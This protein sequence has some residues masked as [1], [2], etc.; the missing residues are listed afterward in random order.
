M[1]KTKNTR[2]GKKSVF[3]KIRKIF[4]WVLIVLIVIAG[5][6]AL[7]SYYYG[8]RIVRE[9]LI[10][11]VEKGSKGLY[12]VKMKNLYFNL[13][14]GRVYVSGFQLIPDTALYNRQQ[15]KDTL[16][17]MLIAINIAKFQVQ[18]I[19]FYKL[20]KDR[21]LVIRKIL[22]ENPE[23]TLTVRRP[24]EKKEKKESPQKQLSIP[25]P[26]ALNSLHILE[27]VLKDGKLLFDNRTVSPAEKFSIPSLN[28]SLKNIQVDSTHTGKK[29]I[30]NTDDIRV[31]LKGMKM[32]TKDSM[33]T[34]VP[35]EIGL[36]TGSS[37]FWVRDFEL[38]PNYSKAGF[39]KKLGYQMD[40]MEISVRKIDITNIDYRALILNLKF[41]AGQIRAEGLVFDD[42][43]DK[44]TPLRPNFMPPLPQQAL[45]R[46]K[47]YIKIDSVTLVD[48]KVIYSEQVGE[49]PGS[50]FFDKMKVTVLNVTNDSSLVLKKTVMAVN[51]SMYLMG[52]GLLRVNLK[53]PLGEKNDAFSFSATLGAME[54]NSIN[55]M[56][57]NLVPAK[58]NG[59]TVI[60]LVIPY[61]YADNDKS[62][63]TMNFSYKGLQLEMKG[64][65]EDTWSKIKAG[66]IT[67]VANTYVKNENPTASGKFTKGM[68]YFERDKHKSIFNFLWKSAFSG[69]KS[70]IGINKKEQ[71]E[72]KKAQKKK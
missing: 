52:K 43:R 36:S 13:V 59:G 35:G 1:K 27:I 8:T 67:F 53:I 12:H 50:M 57:T 28:V 38:I 25:L 48:G 22:I 39:S 60:Q 5:S 42:Y 24:S 51:A 3:R 55:P 46:S 65:P 2:S 44:R 30:F 70:T 14:T 16:S 26:K 17:P 69:I 40:R 6:A 47:M 9:S 45:L 18:G 23:V 61:V 62:T 37:S 31:V 4:L 21:D 63:G 66:A 19:D 71:K 29:R 56:L 33:Y 68:I 54:L 11:A 20:A 64:V 72:M 10:S 41:I 15:E 49:K 34:V 32:N 58:I 7:I